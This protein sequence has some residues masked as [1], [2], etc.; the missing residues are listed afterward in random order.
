MDTSN[1]LYRD[2]FWLFDQYC[3]KNKSV[4]Q[5]RRENGF[6]INTVKRWLKTFG[7]DIRQPGN[8]IVSVQQGKLPDDHT[9]SYS[10]LHLVIR[11]ELPDFG[12][13]NICGKETET[14]D[15]ANISGEYKRDLS[16]WEWLCRSCHLTNDHRKR[17]LRNL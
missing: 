15:C 1:M 17:K 9:L 13:C 3:E 7:I 5:I 8:K 16:D 14:L 12:K 6:G 4:R 11:A 2:K 10:R